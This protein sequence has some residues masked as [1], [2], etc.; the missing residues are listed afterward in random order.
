MVAVV[1]PWGMVMNR[2]LGWAALCAAGLLAFAGQ[3][4]ATIVDVAISAE[5]YQLQGPAGFYPAGQSCGTNYATYCTST[6]GGREFIDFHAGGIPYLANF[7]F[8]TGVGGLST[9]ATSQTLSWNAAMGTPS[10]LLSGSFQFGQQNLP[11]LIDLDLTTATS[12]V[13]ERNPF[14]LFFNISSPDFGFTQNSSVIVLGGSRLD[15]P[16]TSNCF[17]GGITYADANYTTNLSELFFESVTPRAP[18][19]EPTT[20]AMLILG[21]AAV[22]AALRRRLSPA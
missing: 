21:F 12:F 5:F 4:G 2:Q 7:A 17:C 19:P 15:T 3:A 22:G 11:L 16:G 8:D 14:G 6:G 1:K 9:T 13:I 20:W 10:P 18:A